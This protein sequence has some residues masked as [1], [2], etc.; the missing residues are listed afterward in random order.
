[1]VHRLRIRAHE[2]AEL[3]QEDSVG[4]TTQTPP[5]KRK[6]RRRRKKK[7]V[8]G[9]NPGAREKLLAK[10][11]R[12]SQPPPE[13]PTL[14]MSQMD[15]P[16]CPNCRVVLVARLGK[17]GPSIWCNCQGYREEEVSPTAFA[18]REKN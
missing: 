1:M 4:T 11:A 10:R 13:P 15:T 17:H 16:R 6:R 9:V 5:P 18:E 12:L 3:E 14:P 8:Q 7:A 2:E